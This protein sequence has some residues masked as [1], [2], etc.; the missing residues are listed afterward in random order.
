[1]PRPKRTARKR[2]LTKLFVEKVK[3]ETSRFLVWDTKQHG[4]ALQVEPTGM[5]AWKCIYSF[6]GR[7]R[8]LHIGKTSAIGLSDARTL[9]AE[10]M[11]AVAKGNDPAAEKKAE[12]G[13]G[14][15]AD[16]A[17]RYV[18]GHAKKNNKSWQQ[19]DALVRRYVLPRW[20]KLQAATIARSD[21]KALMRQIAA[22]VLA[23]QV[24]AAVSA[25]FTWA[26]REEILPANPCKLV[27]RNPV[28]SRERVLSQSELPKFWT[29]FGD[30]VQ[31]R[32]LKAILLL[33]QRP[34]EIAH[35]RREHIVDGWWELPGDPAPSLG[36]PGT[37][38]KQPHRV[39]LPE[40]VRD[41][42]DS[43]ETTSFVFGSR[44]PVHGLDTVMRD[45]SKQ[46]GAEPV[47]PH[48]LRRTHGSAITALGFGR[49]AMNRIQ[50]HKEGGIA[51]VYDRHEYADENKRVMEAVAARI[52]ALVEEGSP[53]NVVPMGIRRPS[54]RNSV[55]RSKR[56]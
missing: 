55:S 41:I 2:T 1:M 23:N 28:K 14:T 15:F 39:W 29:A 43:D 26:L 11:L 47:R 5:R 38:N 50:N 56:H 44:R 42:I 45:I 22:P 19:G 4:L 20:G 6:H 16:L 49:D 46:L 51:S 21:V 37:K 7:P 18:E 35:M 31:G 48:D 25:V 13:A 36:W 32:A 10:A 27:A 33:G 40:R 52:M 8:W 34:G 30:S 24:L 3:P 54:P 53:G 17:A 9:A 12:R